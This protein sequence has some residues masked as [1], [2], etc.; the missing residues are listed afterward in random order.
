MPLN[1]QCPKCE[2]AVRDGTRRCPLCATPLRTGLGSE[3]REE[4]GAPIVDPLLDLFARDEMV[5]TCSWCRNE[6][7][8]EAK[9]C[10]PCGS[11]TIFV[12]RSKYA[13]DLVARPI[14]DRGRVIA[15]GPAIPAR[16]LRRAKTCLDADDAA[17]LLE[18]FRAYGV[19]AWAGTDAMEPLADD[20]AVGV[21]IRLA[22]WSAADYLI[23]GVRVTRAER[24]RDVDGRAADLRRAKLYLGFGRW[25]RAAA[26]AGKYP[27]DVAAEELVAEALLGAGRVREADRRAAAARAD[28]AKSA[29]RLKLLAGATAA[30][31]NDGTPFGAGS[32]P[33][34]AAAR[35]E[36]ALARE[37]R[38][39]DA[40]KALVETRV[41]LG[42]V[43]AAREELRR[44]ARLNPNLCAHDGWFRRQA[45]A[46]LAGA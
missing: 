12:A 31:G 37:P 45:S 5:R 10:K 18:E 44:L 23:S 15:A 42:R 36:E 29:A 39:C 46:P 4:T 13:A 21:W 33:H 35:L 7:T 8:A 14:G 20:D 28:D 11:A 2:T 9:R 30:L 16:E 3:P 6:F 40:G 38:F 24:P 41:A 26:L 1:L 43:A 32:D 19:D 27:G 22:D 34:A 17:I 25:R